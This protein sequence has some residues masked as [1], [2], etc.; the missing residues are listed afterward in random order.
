MVCMCLI[1]IIPVRLLN[2]YV[3]AVSACC[4]GHQRRCW[5]LRAATVRSNQKIWI[6]HVKDISIRQNTNWGY[7]WKL[8]RTERFAPSQ[9]CFLP[10]LLY[11]YIYILPRSRPLTYLHCV[12]FWPDRMNKQWG[13]WNIPYYNVWIV[14]DVWVLICMI[15]IYLLNLLDSFLRAENIIVHYFHNEG[16]KDY[17]F[18]K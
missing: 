12:P 6:K 13:L 17:Y 2:F 9:W 7:A 14:W 15:Y 11:I 1:D 10:F 4:W 5:W 3:S 18:Q 16:N 8:P